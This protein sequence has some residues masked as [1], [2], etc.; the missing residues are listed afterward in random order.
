MSRQ[1]TSAIKVR[2][3]F[4]VIHLHLDFDGE[5]RFVEATYRAND[6]KVTPDTQIGHFLGQI[7]GGVTEAI[8]E[9]NSSD[10]RLSE[11]ALRVIAAR[12]EQ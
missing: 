1:Q 8:H 2:T 9:A 10:L 3:Q 7:L 12:L 5:G 6:D 4:G 11:S